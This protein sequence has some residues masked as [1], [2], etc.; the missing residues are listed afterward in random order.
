M[1]VKFNHCTAI[2]KGQAYLYYIYDKALPGYFITSIAIADTME[3]KRN[4]SEVLEYFFIEIVRDRTT[5]C[6]LFENSVEFFS[7]YVTTS[8]EYNGM[9][10]YK[11][12]PYKEIVG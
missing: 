4:F 11:M 3:A 1:E 9:T 2:H 6:N 10:V 5:Y 8:Q 12:K 7:K